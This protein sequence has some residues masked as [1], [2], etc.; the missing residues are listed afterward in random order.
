MPCI[1]I[2]HKQL[3]GLGFFIRELCLLVQNF[4][5][6]CHST[7]TTFHFSSG[8]KNQKHYINTFVKGTHFTS[9]IVC[10]QE[11]P[12]RWPDLPLSREP[13][14][15]HE[16]LQWRCG[17]ACR[18]AERPC[19]GRGDRQ[20]GRRRGKRGR[21]GHRS[22]RQAGGSARR[23]QQPL[24]DMGLKAAASWRPALFWPLISPLLRGVGR[25]SYL[26]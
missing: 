16:L 23:S 21:G 26:L 17:L 10:R 6:L 3:I 9:N 20:G 18:R 15:L 25:L 14:H 11:S 4:I 5:F 7:I 8:K 19:W 12:S 13:S 2:P 24:A 1:S 22:G